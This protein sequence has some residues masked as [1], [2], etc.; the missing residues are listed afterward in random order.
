[1]ERGD[2]TRKVAK[3]K[4]DLMQRR[5]KRGEKVIRKLEE[6]RGGMNGGKHNSPYRLS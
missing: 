1:M 2:V 3:T 6:C 5:S 4:N